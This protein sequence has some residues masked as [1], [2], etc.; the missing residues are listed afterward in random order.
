[1]QQLSLAQAR[2]VALAAQGLASVKRPTTVTMRHVQAEI[3][4]VAQFQIDT[5]NVVQ[6]AHYVPLFSR[7]GPYDTS[8]LDRATNRAPRKLFEYWGHAASLVDVALAPA[9]EHRMQAMAAHYSETPARVEERHPGLIE[10]VLAAVAAHGPVT[11]RELERH[12]DHSEER[13]RDSWGWNWSS[14]KQ[15]LEYEFSAG[16]IS[17]AGRNTQFERRY[18]LTE[19]VLPSSSQHVGGTPVEQRRTLLARAGR[20]LGVFS[21]TCVTDY[22][23]L[24]RDPVT[25]EAFADLVASG[26]F[27]PVTVAGWDAT[28]TWLWHEATVPRRATGRALLSPFDSMM[29]QRDRIHALFD[30]F[31]RIEIYVPAAQ[32]VHGYYVYSFLLDD[33]LCARVDLKANRATSRLEVRATWLEPGADPARTVVEL[34]ETLRELADWLGLAEVSAEPRGNGADA[35]V[36]VLSHSG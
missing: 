17:S 4:R 12:L 11:A 23:Y 22:F 18:D 26:E 8:L 6:R 15:V 1:M 32:R 36:R 33:K 24:R 21:L 19:R 25:A 30:Y 16:S 9:M 7:L 13:N 29:F 34:A 5:V 3:D 14:V 2:R 35:L 10:Q 28:P 31:Y 20:A 27:V